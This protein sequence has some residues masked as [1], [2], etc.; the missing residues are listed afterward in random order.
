MRFP[1]ETN[2]D[3]NRRRGLVSRRWTSILVHNINF[4]SRHCLAT[5]A[6]TIVCRQ[7]PL[8]VASGA[9]LL[10]SAQRFPWDSL[11]YLPI[12]GATEMKSNFERPKNA[13]DTRLIFVR[14]FG[15]SRILPLLTKAGS[16]GPK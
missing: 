6:K 12:H 10:V 15:V 8:R 7:R 16:S 4:G 1:Q 5:E 11:H 14:R 2:A 13:A 3:A 9:G